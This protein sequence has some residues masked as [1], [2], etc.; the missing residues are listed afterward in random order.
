MRTILFL[1]S[2]LIFS[3]A[4]AQEVLPQHAI[5]LHGEPKYG[6]AFEHLD[7]V[8]PDAPKNGSLKMG[9]IGA[10]DSLNPFIVKG[11]PAAGLN[12]MRS[13]F[14]YQSLMQNAWDEPFTLYGILAESIEM[15]ED[16]G[17]VTFNLRPEAKWADGQPVTAEDVVWTFN[18]LKEKG[19]PFFK[20]YYG[21]VASV[22]AENERRV[23]FEF[24]VAGNKELPLIIAEMAVI[25]K[26]FWEGKDFDQTSLEAP[27]G[28]GPYKVASVEGGR[29]ITYER[30]PN[31]WGKDLPFFQGFYN[32]ESVTYDYYRDANVALEAFLAG[33]FDIRAENTAKL[34]ANAYN[35]PAVDEGRLIK[36]EIESARPQGM[37]GFVYN[38]R[39]P[40]F[41]DVAVRK[42]L[43]Y[44]F[45]FEWSNKQFAFGVYKRTDS[46]FENSELASSGLPEGEELALL[47]PFRGQIP[48]AVFTEEFTNPVTDGSG[49]NRR[50]LRTAMQIL[51]EA[52][53]VLGEDGVRVKDDVRLE[54]EILDNNPQF[55][56]WVLPFIKNL[57][58]IGAKAS[59][60]VVDSAQYQNRM[61]AFDYDITIG[62]FGQSNSPG[63][64][65]RDYWSSAK[66]DVDGSRNIIGVS[67][68]A[69]DAL[70]EDLIVADSREDLVTHVRALD[71]ILL[72]G[73]YVIPMWH[74][75]IWRIARWEHIQ[76]PEVLSGITPLIPETWWS[77]K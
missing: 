29:S 65:Q 49:N 21:D 55:E 47:E 11:T 45:D 77:S 17:R 73:H 37:Q 72:H 33:E 60:R 51:E 53:W 52:G 39:R 48:D 40:V 2:F 8:N 30:D 14:V 67:G 70:I 26:H 75:N 18:T 58:R 3:P 57:E 28:S 69:V 12:F 34:W 71:R 59:F 22:T 5:A 61:T 16:R 25:P 54:F 41:E 10:F 64:E 4:L 35:V 74:Y 9:V 56:R 23:T 43:N 46:Y 44:A 20:A 6:P 76:R 1:F 63:N 42:A 62:V 13:G 32:F 24:A 19:Q 27:L 31:W 7:Y 36:D 68:P 15:A 38:I 50:N 66:V